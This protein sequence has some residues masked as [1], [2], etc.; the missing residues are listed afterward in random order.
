MFLTKNNIINK[1]TFND[2]PRATRA[3]NNA[4]DIDKKREVMGCFI[5]P[6]IIQQLDDATANL[7]FKKIEDATEHKIRNLIKERTGQIGFSIGTKIKLA[8]DF[9]GFNKGTEG[10]IKKCVRFEEDTFGQGWYVYDVE[11]PGGFPLLR[12]YPNEFEVVN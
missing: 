2:I 6:A 4:T 10:I 9:N 12:M 1:L 5:D 3:L 8:C 7:I 11:I